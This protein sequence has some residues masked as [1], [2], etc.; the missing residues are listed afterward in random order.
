MALISSGVAPS[1]RSTV[2]TESPFFAI[3]VR[4]FHEL[5][6]GT[7]HFIGRRSPRVDWASAKLTEGPA[8]TVAA[9]INII[10]RTIVLMNPPPAPTGIP[11]GRTSATHCLAYAD[12]ASELCPPSYTLTK[13]EHESCDFCTTPNRERGSPTAHT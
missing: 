4:S 13:R 5:P 12:I 8:Q 10:G 2:A 6:P 7:C 11:R 1:S 3:A 9:M